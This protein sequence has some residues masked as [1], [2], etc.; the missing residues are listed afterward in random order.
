M[1]SEI[2]TLSEA[3]IRKLLDD[4]TRLVHEVLNLRRQ[5]R[6]HRLPPPPGK[7]DRIR[8]TNGAGA[9]IPARAVMRVSAVTMTRGRPV[10][11]V[12]KPDTTFSHLYLVNGGAKSASGG[13]GWGTWLLNAGE[14]LY[15]STYTPAIG[16]EWG[17]KSGQWSLVRHRPGFLIRGATAGSGSTATVQAQ[18]RMVTLLIGKPVADMTK[19]TAAAVTPWMPK[20]S[21]TPPFATA[22]YEGSGHSN[23]N[24]LPLGSDLVGGLFCD[25]R[26]EGSGWLAKCLET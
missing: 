20:A 1:S 17:P 25:L 15:D 9:E 18:Q 5:P 8:F 10:Y 13:G 3:A 12:V 6:H 11:T 24:A 26:F 21:S 14:V 2:I 7:L 22:D 23:L 16:E 4:H 19:G